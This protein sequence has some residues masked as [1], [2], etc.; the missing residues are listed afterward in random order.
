MRK[1]I[2][3][4][5]ILIL[6]ALILLLWPSRQ[7]KES[8]QSYRART[9]GYLMKKKGK[10]PKAV[11][12]QRPSDWFYRQRAYPY[13]TIPVAQ[14]RLAVLKAREIQ[15]ASETLNK[16]GQVS[17]WTG[18]GPTNIPGRITDLAVHPS[19]PG[20]IFAASAAG[21]VFKTTD[22]GV[23]WL[24]VF[25]N[26]GAPGMGAVAVDPS[27]PLVVYAGTGEVNPA[28]DTY[29]GDGIYKSTDGGLTWDNV[30]LPYSYRIG[31]IIVDPLFPDTIY[32]AVLGSRWSGNNP[33]RGVYRSQN[34]GGTWEQILYV[35]DNV[36]CVDLALQPEEGVLLAAF[37]ERWEGE[38]SGIW[39]SAN[40]GDTWTNISGTGG[41]PAVALQ[42]GRIGVTIGKDHHTAYA[43]YNGGPVPNDGDFYGLYKSTNL[44]L[45]WTRTD[46]AALVELNASWSGGW[47]FGNVRISPTNPD[48]VYVLG[49]DVWQSTDGGSSWNN[50]SSSSV[51][52]DQHAMYI[53][54]TDDSKL[55]LGCDGGVYY[56]G[57]WGSSWSLMTAMANTQFYAIT[58]DYSH[59][60]RLYGGTQDNGTLRTNTGALDE[61]DQIMG[62]DGFFTLVDFTNPDIIYAEYQYGSLYKS[63]DNG[64]TFAYALEG[65]NPSEPTGWCTPFVMDPNN[66]RILYYGTNRVYRT[67]DGAGQWTAI[68]EALTGGSGVITTI[69]VART[70]PEVVYA[71]T[72]DGAVYVTT[73]GGL[74]WNLVSS[75][76]PQRWITRVTVDPFD[77]GIAY[78]TLS[79]YKQYGDY[80]PH[81]HRTVNYGASW[82]DI[83][84]NLP[85]APINDC[86]VDIHNENTLYI[87]TDVGVFKTDN[88]GNTWS[89]F[90]T[91]LPLS[92]V[93]DLAYHYP[94]RSLVAGTH[95]RSMFRTT[96]D[97]NDPFD[98]DNDGVGNDCDNCPQVYNPEQVDVDMDFIGDACDDCVDWDK[99]GYGNPGVPGNTCA[100]D[101]CPYDY[102]PDQLDSDGDGI[103]DVCD[104][105]S[106]VWDTVT[107][108]CLQL[109]VGSN[110]NYANRGMFGATMD[111]VLTGDC[112][113]NAG[114]YLYDGS[115][116]ICY[117]SGL[118]T[119]ASYALYG[120]QYF[121][122]VEGK[123]ATVPTVSTTAYDIFESGT[124]VSRDS[125]LAMEVTWWSPK[126]S[127]SCQ[128]VIQGMRLYS[129]DGFNH[130]GLYIGNAVDWDI[131]SDNNV[132]NT[133]GYD[134]TRKLIYQQGWEFDG[135]GCQANDARFGGMAFIGYYLNDSC[136][137]DTATQP[138]GA[139]TASNVVY[140]Y[141]NGTFVP[142]ELLENMAQ[143]G[144]RTGG[145]YE[146]QHSVMTCF[147]DYTLLANDTLMLYTVLSSVPEGDLTT[148]TGNINK[149]KKWFNSHVSPRCSCCVGYTG[150]IDCSE[151]EAPDISDI[152]RLIDFLYLSHLP[153]CCKEE[154]DT[155]G[156][157][158]DPDISD[159]TALIDHLYLS[160]K[161]LAICP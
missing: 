103:G 139:Y 79:G 64:N 31:R 55:Y 40:R 3:I 119:L 61:W 56:S 93:H 39:R 117:V 60:E 126:K 123:K 90:G 51:H 143:A 140:I 113:P 41:L 28:G 161:D 81:I 95:G 73:N 33:Y 101:N 82:S 9:T 46:D 57:N 121:N 14:H 145:D 29:E 110:G 32:V 141:P 133:G 26:Q 102:N 137:V 154:T 99:D 134:V 149:A 153:L 147:A 159:I 63:I 30:G 122:L 42:F 34:G 4:V 120:R 158:G 43:L 128:F 7:K 118:D 87:A 47:Y 8:L 10:I 111:Y 53:L 1:Y 2:L 114:V 156:S 69:D 89:T 48:I 54:E 49:L 77:A 67:I 52:V 68:S 116:V 96:I 98:S 136:L 16:E 5:P 25:D 130:E 45:N 107:T 125:T 72:S 76:L 66:A 85:D 27:N 12:L 18:A 20:T 100:D 91:D 83:S 108:P 58:I 94:T 157:G 6:I 13:D 80:L 86:I 105:R 44:G 155:D 23:T 152:S 11:R 36:G 151:S 135:Q 132:D 15:A 62:G 150:N 115:P 127:D 131:P 144:Y 148:L 71:G 142:T 74:N 88:L 75:Q 59:P 50:I 129:Y 97:C 37:W 24:P 19:Y 21:G 146:D 35:A 78:V 22:F 138:Y 124:F 112:D 17:V 38:G 160:H 65:V 106:A 104:T 70:E 92:V 109:T 84:G